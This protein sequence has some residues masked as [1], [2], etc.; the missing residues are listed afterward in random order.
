M[1]SEK[2]VLAA[3]REAYFKLSTKNLRFPLQ[4]RIL[5]KAPSSAYEIF[6]STRTA[7]PHLANCDQC[8]VGREFFIEIQPKVKVEWIY[9]TLSAFADIEI[10]LW[11]LPEAGKKNFFKTIFGLIGYD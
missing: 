4:G 10:K 9:F 11:I 6:A 8:F 7:K 3:N 2:F 1:H 5:T